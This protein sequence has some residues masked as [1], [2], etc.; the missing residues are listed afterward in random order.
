M[1]LK[2]YNRMSSHEPNFV[3][4]SYIAQRLK[5]TGSVLVWCNFKLYMILQN[6]LNFLYDFRKLIKK[7]VERRKF[8]CCP[9]NNQES[10]M[11]FSQFHGVFDSFLQNFNVLQ[12]FRGF[13]MYLLT[14]L[15]IS[16]AVQNP[17]E[18]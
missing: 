14:Q 18:N 12:S 6:T 17:E 1:V 16:V 8:N 4:L 11:N 7:I 3:Y 9:D 2:S 10:F 15:S 13:H 5:F